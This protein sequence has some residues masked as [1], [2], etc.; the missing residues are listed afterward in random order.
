MTD[1]YT[2]MTD[3]STGRDARYDR[4]T[5]MKAGL[6]AA[7]TA[8]IGTAPAAASSGSAGQQADASLEDWLSNVGNFDG[9]VD[10]RG[11]SEVTVEVG[12]KGNNGSYA[13]GPAVVRVDPGTTVVFEW[14]GKGGSHNVVADDGSY[15]SKMQGDEG[16]TFEQSFDDTGVSRYYCGPHEPMGMKGAVV[17]GDGEV[18][19][20]STG[21]AA[22]DAADGSGASGERIDYDGWFEN[23]GNFDGTVD[24]TGESEVTVTV[25][26]EGNDGAYAFGPAAVRVDPGTTVTWEW[27]GAGGSHNVVA[28]DGG[29][30][31]KMQGDE[32][33][34]FERTFESEGVSK[35]YCGPHEPMGM[36]G[37]VVVGSPNAAA[38]QESAGESDS[39]EDLW[40]YGLVAGLVGALFS[41]L[42]FGA[43][44]HT[45]D[46]V[47]P[48]SEPE[49]GHRSH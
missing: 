15:E 13:F 40:L 41:P 33:A 24:R 42:L 29:Y 49:H 43:F 5:V 27:T 16:A 28:D 8:A 38:G 25:G 34:T 35:Y 45:K 12:A 17:V 23:V 11:A 26:A 4:R 20:P 3:D 10:E 47:T 30:E 9:I 44:L 22:D 21:G 14:T 18:A 36:K 37:A 32:G 48:D 46:D 6:A 19:V 2:P 39:G 1:D 31:S 7:S